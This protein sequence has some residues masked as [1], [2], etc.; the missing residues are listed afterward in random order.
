M[1][2]N[3]TQVVID[4]HIEQDKT[5]LQGKIWML[6]HSG[7]HNKVPYIGCLINSRKLFLTVLEVGGL[8]SWCQHGLG[9][10]KA[11][12]QVSDY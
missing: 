1:L 2:S 11:L 5:I 8:R 12:F 10:V 6:I 4:Y 7:C 9:L 3:H